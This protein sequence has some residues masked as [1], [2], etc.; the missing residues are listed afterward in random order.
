MLGDGAACIQA[1]KAHVVKKGHRLRFFET[2]QHE[3]ESTAFSSRDF[4][5][6]SYASE[7]VS[8]IQLQ[9]QQ[10]MNIEN[11]LHSKRI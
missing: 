3:I 7:I 4:I 6:A 8:R 1:I 10:V 2:K 5:F 11:I 9:Q